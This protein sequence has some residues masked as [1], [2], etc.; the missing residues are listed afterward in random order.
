MDLLYLGSLRRQLAL[1][2][3]IKLG[4]PSEQ[5]I[6][7]I[8]MVLAIPFSFLNYLIHNRTTRLLYSLIIG[9][10]L[11]YSIYGIQSLHTIFGTV[12]SYL[13]VK[14]FGRK[15]SP[16]YLLIAT[17]IHLSILNIIRMITDFGGWA[18]DDISTIYMVEVAK[19]SSFGFSYSDGEKDPKDI[20]NEHHKS[21]RIEEMPSLLEYASYI[22]F[23]P[24]SI[25][26]PFIE[27]K[28]FINFIDEKDCYAELKN[29]MGFII[30]Q[31]IQKLLIS[32][33]FIIIFALF[34]DKFPMSAVGTSEF[35]KN[36]PKWWMRFL[37]L[38]TCG[39]IGRSK[40]YI[41]L[42]LTYSTLIFS[43]MAFGKTITHIIINSFYYCEIIHIFIISLT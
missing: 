18:I 7:I 37:Y 5:I 16:F 22:Y 30:S 4:A 26:G 24:T 33:L 31:G 12:A 43:G 38:Y 2:L 15:I 14:Y 28:D 11:H 32:I 25:V 9:F 19:F 20:F 17:M 1:Y 29:N 27:F 36:Y 40:Y 8:T 21:K 41:A 35:R 42:T 6:L 13:Y 39:P 3:E 23:Y 34:G 10:I